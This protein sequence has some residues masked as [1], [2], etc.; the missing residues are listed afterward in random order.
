MHEKATS[1]PDDSRSMGFLSFLI[2]PAARNDWPTRP[3]LQ[4]CNSRLAGGWRNEV[5]HLCSASLLRE[6]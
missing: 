5:K 6:F 3:S 1:H 2:G 4:L